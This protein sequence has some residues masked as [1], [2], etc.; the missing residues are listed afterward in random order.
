MN[1]KIIAVIVMAVI[2]AGSGGVIALTAGNNSDNKKAS[3]SVSSTESAA[4]S[5]AAEGDDTST[6]DD[7]MPDDSSAVQTESPEDGTDADVTEAASAA[8]ATEGN[9]ESAAPHEGQSIS[10]TMSIQFVVDHSTG[11]E[12]SPRVAFGANYAYC[13]IAFSDDKTFEMCIDPASGA[14]RK[15]TYQVYDDVVSVVYDDGVGSEYD[16]LYDDAGNISHVIVNYGDY[17]VYFA[18]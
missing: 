8:A 16:I 10:G 5:S 4:D 9:T 3:S 13:Y 18:L 6:V 7:S 14:I 15:G 1:K 17:D 12:A 11:A 2:I